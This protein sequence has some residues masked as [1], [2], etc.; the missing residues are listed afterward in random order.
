MKLKEIKVRLYNNLLLKQLEDIFKIHS[1]VD[2]IL[3]ET[4]IYFSK[5]KKKKNYALTQTKI[6]PKLLKGNLKST[7]PKKIFKKKKIINLNQ[8]YKKEQNPTKRK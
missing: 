2:C 8:N 6:Q 3:M 1:P 4:Q 7:I 5:K